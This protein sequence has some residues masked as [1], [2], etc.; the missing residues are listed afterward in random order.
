MFPLFETIAVEHFEPQRLHYHQQRMDE[1]FLRYFH[2][3]N[4]FQLSALFRPET[5]D[6]DGLLKWKVEYGLQGLNSTIEPY[7]PRTIRRVKL[8]EID[9]DFDYSMKFSDRAYF[10][11]LKN[12]N[13]G[14]DELILL[15][16]GELTDSTF[17]NLILEAVSDGKWYTPSTPLLNGTQRQHLIDTSK[18]IPIPISIG[19]LSEYSKIYFVNAMLSLPDAPGIEIDEAIKCL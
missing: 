7:F 3:E 19:Q 11:M 8:V 6:S 1:S 2:R 14:Y 4:P 9:P 13:P 16:N 15:K 17:S 12:Q 18:V 5:V 10:D